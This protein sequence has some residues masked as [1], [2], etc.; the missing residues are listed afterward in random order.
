MMCLIELNF[1]EESI[2]ISTSSVQKYF[3]IQMTNFKILIFVLS[4]LKSKELVCIN[5]SVNFFQIW[6]ELQDKVY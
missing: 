5:C 2:G 1:G 3:P 4:V 6:K